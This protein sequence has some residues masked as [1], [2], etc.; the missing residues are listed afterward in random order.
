[1]TVPPDRVWY[2]YVE[3]P[4][5]PVRVGY[6]QRIASLAEP[7]QFRYTRT[8]QHPSAGTSTRLLEVPPLLDTPGHAPPHAPQNVLRSLNTPRSAHQI[9]LHRFPAEMRTEPQ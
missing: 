5:G 7:S 4:G 3:K 2:I 8:L 9:P 1:M 6:A